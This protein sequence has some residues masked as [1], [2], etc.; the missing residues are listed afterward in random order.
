MTHSSSRAICSI[1][2]RT[3]PPLAGRRSRAIPAGNSRCRPD[4]GVL[5]WQPRF[6]DGIDTSLFA[7]SPRWMSELPARTVFVGDGESRLLKWDHEK[8]GDYDN[9]MASPRWRHSHSRQTHSLPRL[10]RATRR[11]RTVPTRT[12]SLAVDA[13]DS[14]SRRL[15]RRSSAHLFRPNPNSRAASSNA[16]PPIFRCMGMF[17]K[18]HFHMAETGIARSAERCASTPARLVLAKFPIT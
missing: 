8:G 15:A 4:V 11:K 6:F 2:S 7:A 9:S 14:R 3:P 16:P 10:H 1:F 12:P 5:E 13:C 17:M 18:L